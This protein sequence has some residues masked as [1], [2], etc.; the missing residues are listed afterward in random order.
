M[1]NPAKVDPSA[2]FNVEAR[3]RY[4]MPITLFS[5]LPFVFV[6]AITLW[7]IE[8]VSP[9]G[10]GLWA[11]MICITG[12]ATAIWLTFQCSKPLSF[13]AMRSYRKNLELPLSK[14]YSRDFSTNL[15]VGFSPGRE[16][17]IYGGETSWD[18]GFL[19]I[20]PER[21]CYF[22]DQTGFELRPGELCSIEVKRAPSILGG[23]HKLFIE[24]SRIEGGLN[25][26]EYISMELRD[27]KS[28]SELREQTNALLSTLEKWNESFLGATEEPRMFGYPPI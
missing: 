13:R 23:F 7:A 3:V 28:A 1:N 8:L 10:T 21:L 18:V 9:D 12:G 20:E 25:F 22:G 11:G 4:M 5:F 14:K 6:M 2:V 17:R 15:H 27:C 16:L 26:R 24:W 19:S